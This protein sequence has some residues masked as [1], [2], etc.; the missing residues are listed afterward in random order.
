[1]ASTKGKG[2]FFERP[3]K[4]FWVINQVEDIDGTWASSL[5]KAPPTER[6]TNPLN[7]DY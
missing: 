2:P 6:Q 4:D 1:M 5:L 3:W 7:P